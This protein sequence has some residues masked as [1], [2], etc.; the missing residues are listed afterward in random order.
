MSPS[1][2]SQIWQ[3]SLEFESY[4]FALVLYVSGL[5]AWPSVFMHNAECRSEVTIGVVSRRSRSAVY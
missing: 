3:R 2:G 4:T 1:T 5:A